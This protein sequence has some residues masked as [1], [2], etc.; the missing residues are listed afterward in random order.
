MTTPTPQDQ[1]WQAF[2]TKIDQE[3]FPDTLGDVFQHIA[4]RPPALATALST[5]LYTLGN[6]QKMVAAHFTRGI[7][8]N[9]LSKLQMQDDAVEVYFSFPERVEGC[10]RVTQRGIYSEMTHCG[11]RWGSYHAPLNSAVLRYCTLEDI[12]LLNI[13]TSYF[14]ALERAA[15]ELAELIRTQRTKYQ[16]QKHF[17]VS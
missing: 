5:M 15:G 17:S 9:S 3:E 13:L 11:V 1:L 7:F 4:G 2:D 10:L 12:E 14:E 6:Y 16:N 8:V